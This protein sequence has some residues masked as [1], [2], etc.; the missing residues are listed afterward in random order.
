MKKTVAVVSYI[1]LGV[2]FWCTILLFF[3]GTWWCLATL[4][5]F[6]VAVVGIVSAARSGKILWRI[7]GIILLAVHVF[8]SI[9]VWYLFAA[10]TVWAPNP[11]EY[12][13]GDCVEVTAC[14]RYHTDNTI[15]FVISEEDVEIANFTCLSLNDA[16]DA[17]V[18]QNGIEQVDPNTPVTLM[19][20]QT[21]GYHGMTDSDIAGVYIEDTVYLDFETGLANLIQEASVGREWR[22]RMHAMMVVLIVGSLVGMILVITLPRKYIE[23]K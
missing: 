6:A 8:L 15:E 18:K 19:L 21:S 5:V 2:S 20:V 17:L 11:W 7:F 9:F 22:M 1:L 13:K 12:E 3:S 23:E 10:A 16:S 4:A 14:W